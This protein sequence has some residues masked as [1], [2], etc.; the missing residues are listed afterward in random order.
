MLILGGDKDGNCNVERGVG[1]GNSGTMLILGRDKNGN[2]NVD[3][4]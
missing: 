3:G 2:Y 1:M 4:R